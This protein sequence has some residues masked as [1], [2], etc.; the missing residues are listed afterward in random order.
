LWAI[1]EFLF[2]IPTV[3][4]SSMKSEWVVMGEKKKKLGTYGGKAIKSK[5]KTRLEIFYDFILKKERGILFSNKYYSYPWWVF[6][7]E[8]FEFEMIFLYQYF[9][10]QRYD[11]WYPVWNVASLL[12]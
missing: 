12:I 10:L 4:I 6:G 5:V 2:N 7:N 9:K 1:P 8:A 11:I 3:V